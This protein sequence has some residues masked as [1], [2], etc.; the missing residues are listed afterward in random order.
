VAA[1][2]AARVADPA[3]AAP[4][5]RRCA[6]ACACACACTHSGSSRE[7]GTRG[8]RPCSAHQVRPRLSVRVSPHDPHALT[9]SV[10]LSACVW[11]CVSRS[12]DE[13]LALLDASIKTSDMA[14]A[15]RLLRHAHRTQHAL[16]V[17]DPYSDCGLYQNPSSIHRMHLPR[18]TA[19]PHTLLPQ[20]NGARLGLSLSLLSLSLFDAPVLV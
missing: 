15:D 8:A 17:R 12:M 3:G 20:R 13:T 1:R 18:P 4:R 14:R 2:S 16:S 7:G 11:V 10:C 19:Y 9:V 6:C 5:D